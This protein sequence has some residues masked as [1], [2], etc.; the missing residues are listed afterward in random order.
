M[1]PHKV[2]LA[3]EYNLRCSIIKAIKYLMFTSYLYLI[4]KLKL[5]LKLKETL[6]SDNISWWDPGLFM[7]I[8]ILPFLPLNILFDWSLKHYL[9]NKY[10]LINSN[11]KKFIL[12]T[13]Q[14]TFVVVL[15]IFSLSL[16]VY[17][18]LNFKAYTFLPTFFHPFVPPFITSIFVLIGS[19]LIPIFSI[20][21][22]KYKNLDDQVLRKVNKLLEKNRFPKNQVK[23]QTSKEKTNLLKAFFTGWGP[24]KRI[25]FSESFIESASS[26]EFEVVTAHELG[27]YR[28]GHILKGALMA[29][30]TVFFYQYILTSFIKRF[31][32]TVGASSFPDLIN[33]PVFLFLSLLLS[34]LGIPLLLSIMREWELSVDWF[35]IKSTRNPRAFIS[36]MEKFVEINLRDPKPN[37]LIKLFFYTHPP[38]NDRIDLAKKFKK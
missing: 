27:H 5:A 7:I 11:T 38:I 35:A 14:S 9:P 29:F 23:V 22:V 16:L 31:S 18:S 20:F 36:I 6:F 33:L 26:E 15:L 2:I 4:L 24:F 25:V 1:D 13:L 10:K 30:L 3:K 34:I 8:L 21:F 37:Y 19:F 12:K 17:F 28:H 32:P